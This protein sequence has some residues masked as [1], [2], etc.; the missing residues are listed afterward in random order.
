MAVNLSTIDWSR[1]PILEV[2]EELQKHLSEDNKRYFQTFSFPLDERSYE[3][4][5]EALA[6]AVSRTEHYLNRRRELLLL[7]GKP[8]AYSWSV[9]AGVVTFTPDLSLNP[10]ATAWGRFVFLD[11]PQLL[12][13]PVKP[14]DH[15][16]HYI[17]HEFAHA[18]FGVCDEDTAQDLTHRLYFGERPKQKTA[19]PSVW[20]RGKT[21]A[22]VTS[23][24]EDLETTAW[25]HTRTS[26][27]CR[28]PFQLHHP[29]ASVV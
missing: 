11:A 1:V 19:L 20:V 16:A 2:R 13:L 10:M 21:V 15:A 4:L 5:A 9:G 14:H 22:I 24:P 3:R 23:Q 8:P 27:V 25:S 6:T 26:S 17:V 12:K 29:V 28:S 18:L 7:F